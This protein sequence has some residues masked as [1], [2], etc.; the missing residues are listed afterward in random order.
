MMKRMWLVGMSALVVACASKTPEATPVKPA[1]GTEGTAPAACVPE[2]PRVPPV[3]PWKDAE[4]LCAEANR[5]QP[6]PGAKPPLGPD[7]PQRSE[8]YAIRVRDFLRSLA[9]RQT[10]YSWLSDATWR[11]TGEYEGCTCP[12]GGQNCGVSKGPHPAVRIYYSPE[13][14]TWMCKYR[15]GKDQL[16]GA[17]DLPDGAMI[18]KEMINPDKVNLARVPGTDKLW[19][20]PMPGQP[21]DDTFSS[22]T[23]MIKA[24]EASADGW[25]WAFFDKTSTGNPPIWDRTA[26]SMKPYPGEGGQ[27]VTAP[28]PANPWLPTY[29]QYSVN[30]VQFPNYEFGNYCV[31]CHASAQ[32]QTTFASFTN[33]LGQE[34]LYRWR[35]QRSQKVDLDDHLRGAAAAEALQ[36]QTQAAQ[37]KPT[38]SAGPFPL[39]RDQPLPGFRETFPELNPPYEEVWA[40]RLP[41]QTYDHEVSR[42]GVKGAVPKSHQFLTSDQCQSC[43]EAGGSGQLELP[44]MV[45][46]VGETQVDLS[47]WAEWSAS[48]MGLAGRDP[49]FHSQLELERNIAREEPGLASIRD[50]IDNTCLHCHGAPGARQYNIDTQGQGP[51]GDPCAAFLPPKAERVE[52]DYAGALFTHEMVFAWRGE[53]PKYAKYGGLARDGINCTICHHISD[54]DLD[55]KNLPKTF[56]GNFRVG[57]PEK[58]YGPFP[59]EDSKEPVRPKPMEN[60][61]GITPQAGAQI[62]SSELCGTCHTVFLPVFND[63][64]RLAGTA[65]EQSTYLE[66]L[67]SDFSTHGQGGQAGKSCQDCHMDN[68]YHGKK[69]KTGIANVQDTRYPEADFLLPAQDVDIPLRPYNRHKLYGL[70]VFLNAFVQQ[71]PLLIGYRQQDFMNGN[72]QP[73]LLTGL[74]SVL[75]VAREETAELTLG[76]L[77]WRPEGLEVAVTVKN[78]GGHSLPSGVGFRRLFLEVVVLDGAGQPLWASGRTNDLGVLL[79]GTTQEALPTEFWQAGPGGLPFQPHYQLITDESQAQ[80]YEEVTQNSSLEFTSSFLHRYWE[81]KDNRLRPRGYTPTRVADAQRRVEYG[82]ATRPGTGP[83]RHW[84][85]K[86][87]W[88]ERYR[89]PKYPAIE[90]YT[91]TKGDPDY[92]L[93]GPPQGLPGTDSLVYRMR[94]SAEQRAAAKRVR[95]TLYSQSAP[96]HFL[97]ERFQYAAQ[98]GAERRAAT[99]LYYMAGHLNTDATGPGGE[100][101]LKGYKLQVGRSAERELPAP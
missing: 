19:I 69:L 49:I 84:W 76:R 66:W 83:E 59:S 72:V 38:P 89:D 21:Y 4:Q 36:A 26:F 56:T 31:Y 81:I 42:L 17:E 80:I 6:W 68:D 9:Y 73:P 77:E 54:K 1:G 100:P 23:V 43:H 63:Q 15:K 11:L 27:P 3:V 82:E 37:A 45:E 8:E 92:T 13:V 22:W 24:P 30:D 12:Q 50:C 10:P 5:G 34:I 97:K 65:Y 61:L 86:P 79:K 78:L 91:D 44:Y 46:K 57:P 33:L 39:P 71:Y 95:V 93:E 85:P 96:P 16:P 64:G 88:L 32:G 41:A 7:W 40:S 20:A 101:Y 94:L 47:E 29:W 90:R 51:A 53:N 52:T 14:I 2:V 70:N 87:A 74:S 48:P 35:P 18:I 99:Q 75:E 67:L 62:R 60:T 55:P 58:L 25:Y 28:P 98:S